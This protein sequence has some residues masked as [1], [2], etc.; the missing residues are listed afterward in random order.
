MTACTFLEAANGAERSVALSADSRGRL[1]FHNVT[2]YLSITN[3][4][5]GVGLLFI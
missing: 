2:S 1:V 5:A 3:F 4:L